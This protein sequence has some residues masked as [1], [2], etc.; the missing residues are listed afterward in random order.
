MAQALVALSRLPGVGLTGIRQTLVMDAQGRVECP[1]HMGHVQMRFLRPTRAAPR[2]MMVARAAQGREL[3]DAGLLR[4]SSTP[5]ACTELSRKSWHV[6]AAGDVLASNEAEVGL[7]PLGTWSV[8][9]RGRWR[10]MWSESQG[11]RVGG[12]ER[13]GAVRCSGDGG[14]GCGPQKAARCACAAHSGHPYACGGTR[15]ACTRA[16]A[17]LPRGTCRW[18]LR[19]WRS[20]RWAFLARACPSCQRCV[21]HAALSFA[22]PS[23]LATGAL[24]G[25]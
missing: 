7:G 13:G 3:I 5:T 15:R 14:D 8:S 9:I 20:S 21:A 25:Q 23:L 19:S 16:E 22:Q 17:P 18:H 11:V 10:P 1:R 4:L 12:G 6:V 24:L 2:Q